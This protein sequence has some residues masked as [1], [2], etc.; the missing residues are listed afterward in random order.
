[1]EN[2]MNRDKCFEMVSHKENKH[3]SQLV[4]SFDTRSSQGQ[5][6]I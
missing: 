5:K 2:M 4:I 6:I 3:S 1:M